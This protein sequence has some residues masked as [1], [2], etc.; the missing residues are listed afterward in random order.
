MI[1]LQGKRNSAIVFAEKIDKETKKRISELLS[2][3]AFSD[4]K[5]RIMP[6]AHASKSAVV[7]TSMTL[8]G[9]VHREPRC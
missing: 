9:R 1:T 5:I 6:D 8:C 7:G 3:E 2:D 4:S